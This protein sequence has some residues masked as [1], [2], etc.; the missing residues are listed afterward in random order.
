M[1]ARHVLFGLVS[2]AAIAG[3]VWV[4][5]PSSSTPSELPE[6]QLPIA[7]DSPNAEP[8]TPLVQPD[9]RVAA[10]TRTVSPTTA[11]VHG[12]C[13]SASTTA[14]LAGITAELNGR[15]DSSIRQE[16]DRGP[17][18]RDVRTT[19]TADGRFRLE[20]TPPPGYRIWLQLAAAG[21]LTFA[22]TLTEL[23]P[24]TV[25]DLGDI[26]MPFGA[27]VRGRVLDE[28]GTPV[29]GVTVTVQAEATD[30]APSFHVQTFW[31]GASDSTGQFSLRSPLP[32][33]NWAL[34]VNQPFTLDEPTRLT[35]PE[36]V[37][38]FEVLVRLRA[39]AELLS[40]SGRVEH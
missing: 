38:D 6:P 5:W 29:A 1:A 19:T 13:L 3:V 31:S 39:V 40:V 12:R 15:P 32:I 25:C 36:G 28:T 17:S 26:G 18:W 33:G 23:Q 30:M 11:V 9:P 35:V 7:G 24:G 27:S 20:C 22:T 21:R 8:A 14:P 10:A 34:G 37:N 2:C 4:V 16:N